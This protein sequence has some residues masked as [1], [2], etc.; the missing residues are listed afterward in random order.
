MLKNKIMSQFFI[1]CKESKIENNRSFYG[2]FHLGPFEPSQ[3]ITI[4]N[5]L[6]RTLLSELYGLSIISVE[7]EGASHEYSSLNG[8]KDSVLDILLNIKEVVFKKTIASIGI[9]PQIGYLK[10]RGPGVIHASD[11]RLQPVIQCV[12]PDQYI[13][14]L[15][16][17]GF[18]NMKFVIQYSN[19]WLSTAS[20]NKNKDIISQQQS[21]EVMG[22]TTSPKEIKTASQKKLNDYNSIFNLHLKKRR[23]IFKKLKQIGLKSSNLYIKMLISGYIRLTKTSLLKADLNSGKNINNLGTALNQL[24]F[25]LNQPNLDGS[26][27]WIPYLQTPTAKLLKIK[28]NDNFSLGAEEPK[29]IETQISK[30]KLLAIAYLTKINSK[31]YPAINLRKKNLKKNFFLSL[32][33][34]H[35]NKLKKKSFESNK[36]NSYERS[37]SQLIDAYKASS[38]FL[39][40]NSLTIDAIFNPVTKVNYIIEVNDFKTTQKKFD[41]SS[42]T[43]ELFDIVRNTDRLAVQSATSWLSE[44]K[45]CFVDFSSKRSEHSQ[46]LSTSWT[47]S[48]LPIVNVVST[49]RANKNSNYLENILEIKREIN[50]SKKETI[51]HNIIFEIWTNGSMHP[52]DA[53]YQGFKNLVKLFSKLN[54][55]NSFMINPLI[56]NSTDWQVNHNKN[57]EIKKNFFLKKIKQNN[58]SSTLTDQT[59]STTLSDLLSLNETSFLSTYMSP[60]LKDF[61]LKNDRSLSVV[62]PETLMTGSQSPKEITGT[63]LTVC[64]PPEIN[65]P[66]ATDSKCFLKKN[67]VIKPL[68]KSHN[69]DNFNDLNLSI[70]NLS[71][72]SYTCLKRFNLNTIEELKLFLKNKPLDYKKLSKVCLQEIEHSLKR[73]EQRIL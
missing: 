62:V 56:Y 5:A 61:Y 12:D 13:A 66:E 1:S 19:K 32:S 59:L 7:I 43:L 25:Q 53:I 4:A 22:L 73:I 50:I 39:N 51:K 10:A 40:S 52:R 44:E 60:K 69:S 37:D 67:I 46:K 29:L 38:V 26:S 18:L 71:L 48:Q 64:Q 55:I 6:R 33:S 63:G 20:Q 72:R 49:E 47:A 3:S 21:S 70:L 57:K 17:D 36:N 8:V 41:N 54:K 28:K 2:C 68:G 9:K 15:A 35:V 34:G 45:T 30:K 31:K 27:P 16:D 24:P 23:L 11:L 58:V 65:K 42:E 14:T